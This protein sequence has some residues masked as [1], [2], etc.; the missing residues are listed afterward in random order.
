MKVRPDG[1]VARGCSVVSAHRLPDGAAAALAVVVD[2]EV[3]KADELVERDPLHELLLVPG[4][5]EDWTLAMSRM[6]C[7]VT[8]PTTP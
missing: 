1:D 8:A 6:R 7:T 5:S 3:L 4:A 2:K